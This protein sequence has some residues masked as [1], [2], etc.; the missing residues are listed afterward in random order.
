MEGRC[1]TRYCPPQLKELLENMLHRRGINVK[2]IRTSHEVAHAGKGVV[3]KYASPSR[4]KCKTK[5]NVIRCCRPAGKSVVLKYASPSRVKCKTKKNVT[6]CC[7]PVGKGVVLKYASL[8]RDKCKVY[9]NVTRG[10]PPQVL[11][12]FLHCVIWQF[13]LLCLLRGAKIIINC[14]FC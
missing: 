12:A 2:Y 13:W 4:V 5:K 11:C 14:K 7:R 8:S 10:C 9:K 1:L 3:L 6:R